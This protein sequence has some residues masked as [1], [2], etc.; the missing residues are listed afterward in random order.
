MSGNITSMTSNL[1]QVY[2]FLLPVLL[3]TNLFSYIMYTCENVCIYFK[4]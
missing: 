4:D 1:L 2:V 3:K